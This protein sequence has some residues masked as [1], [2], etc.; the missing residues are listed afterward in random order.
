MTD[1]AL[2]LLPVASVSRETVERLVEFERLIRK[3]N[4][5]INLISKPSLSA[6]WGRHIVDSAQIYQ[7][8]PSNAAKCL[9]IGSGGGLPGIVLAVISAE[10]APERTFTLVE[11][12]QRKSAFLR[13]A[14]R[15]LGLKVDVRANRVES[16]DPLAA[17][18]LSARALAPLS[19]L[20]VSAQR[21]LSAGGTCLFPKG[22]SYMKEISDAQ[23]LFTFQCVAIQSLTDE[24]GAILKIHGIRNA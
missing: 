7:H 24:K 3:W 1:S 9:D 21:H 22:E 16:L 2:P 8:I 13:E 5:A 4:P 15:N 20:L 11:S 18:L 23:K 17:D 19:K 14:S 12:D 6:F 10:L